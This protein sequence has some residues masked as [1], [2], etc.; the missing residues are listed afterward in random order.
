[1]KQWRVVVDWLRLLS[2]DVKRTP[3]ATDQDAG[4]LLQA[5]IGVDHAGSWALFIQYTGRPNAMEF[6]I[7]TKQQTSLRVCP[8]AAR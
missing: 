4:Y 7:G 2:L 8:R 1:M 3:Q 6:A 5:F